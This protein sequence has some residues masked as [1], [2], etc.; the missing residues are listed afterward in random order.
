[1]APPTV[2]NG[3]GAYIL[4]P[5]PAIHE[6]PPMPDSLAALLRASSRDPSKRAAEITDTTSAHTPIPPGS[7]REAALMRQA[8]RAAQV[9]AGTDRAGA[10]GSAGYPTRVVPLDKPHVF[11][12]P[13]MRIEFSHARGTKRACPVT[14]IEHGSNHF[15]VALGAEEERTGL[16]AFFVYCHS[17]KECNPHKRHLM[18]AFVDPASYEA[19]GINPTGAV[20]A[21]APVLSIGQTVVLLGEMQKSVDRLI[22]NPGG[23]WDTIV[24]IG[25]VACALCTAASKHPTMVAVATEMLAQLLSASTMS[26][27]EKEHASF[28]FRHANAKIDPLGTVR[29]YAEGLS[30]KRDQEL[31]LTREAIVACTDPALEADIP[32]AAE[33]LLEVLQYCERRDAG[34]KVQSHGNFADLGLFL[35]FVWRRV[36]RYGFDRTQSS[37]AHQWTLYLFNGATYERGQ[38]EQLH[39]KAERHMRAA[40]SALSSNVL[41]QNRNPERKRLVPI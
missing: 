9:R 11:G 18:L 21:E 13:A 10:G 25:F 4:L 32:K 2:V 22:E 8:L 23:P 38:I 30:G 7:E 17:A 35:Y 36:A 28:G 3:G 27:T 5:G 33:A 31:M 34:G 41:I 24:N 16:P 39:I 12:I 29:G 15:F 19:L 14:R 6:A 1:M 20:A 40:V 37:A 26:A